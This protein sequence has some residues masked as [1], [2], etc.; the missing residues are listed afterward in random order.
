MKEL[1][2]SYFAE[3]LS[4][5]VTDCFFQLFK[6]MSNLDELNTI[7][8]NGNIKLKTNLIKKKWF[9]CF[10]FHLELQKGLKLTS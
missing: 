9:S 7:I 1:F 6:K 3:F 10:S 8:A 2:I 4:L 5:K